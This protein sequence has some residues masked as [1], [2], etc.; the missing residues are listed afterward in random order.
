[1]Q[2]WKLKL[3]GQLLITINPDYIKMLESIETKHFSSIFLPH[4]FP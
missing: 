1:M 2:P 3:S 4:A